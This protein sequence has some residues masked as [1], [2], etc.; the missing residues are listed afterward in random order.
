MFY[1]KLSV[2]FKIIFI[3]AFFSF[4][5][6]KSSYAEVITKS[7]W[8]EEVS[9]SWEKEACNKDSVFRLC[10]LISEKDCFSLAT[11][12]AEGCKNLFKNRLP[13]KISTDKTK[14]DARFNRCANSEFS[15]R[16]SNSYIISEK[17]SCKVK[18]NEMKSGTKQPTK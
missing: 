17:E 1:Y 4:L 2:Q 7:F 9:G 18:V 16:L 11:K 15:R 6:F 14:L 12:T 8:L 13:E 10:Y 3:V 5:P